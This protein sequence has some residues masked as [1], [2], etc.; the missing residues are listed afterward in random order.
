M[1]DEFNIYTVFGSFAL[2][3]AIQACASTPE[4]PPCDA[5]TLAT[6]T[7]TCTSEED[8][9]AKIDQR[10]ATCAKRIEDDK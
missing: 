2:I 3:G 10:Q 7:A 6:I 5:A 4:K 1:T 9:N 8:C